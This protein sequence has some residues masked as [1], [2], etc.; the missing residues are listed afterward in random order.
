MPE[1]MFKINYSSPCASH[2]T[3]T[4]QIVKYWNPLTCPSIWKHKVFINVL[5]Q[6]MN[7]AGH[8]IEFNA[9]MALFWLFCL[10]STHTACPR[11]QT[12]AGYASARSI[13]YPSYIY[14]YETAFHHMGK[15]WYNWFLFM[16]SVDKSCATTSTWKPG[17]GLG[18]GCN[19]F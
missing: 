14:M 9:K 1:R 2:E 12:I 4:S 5:L 8:S 18:W 6:S 7:V 17:H 3:A 13:T 16:V 10:L 15:G 11:I 19:F